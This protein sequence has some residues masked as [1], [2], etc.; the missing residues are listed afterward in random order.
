MNFLLDPENV[1]ERLQVQS[2]EVQ[3]GHR[4]IVEDLADVRQQAQDIYQRIGKAAGF[5]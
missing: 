3:D 4:V 5:K 1:S 2:S